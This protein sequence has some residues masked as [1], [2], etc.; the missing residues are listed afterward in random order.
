[1]AYCEISIPSNVMQIVA[2]LYM[3]KN[4]AMH[5]VMLNVP[6]PGASKLIWLIVS[7]VFNYWISHFRAPLILTKI[8]EGL[9]KTPKWKKIAFSFGQLEL[10]WN[11]CERSLMKSVWWKRNE[12]KKKKKLIFGVVFSFKTL[13]LISIKL[14]YLQQYIMFV[15]QVT[16]FSNF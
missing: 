9:I 1:M 6:L 3:F 5:V 8:R 11:D 13:L 4:L 12:K 7:R 2:I 16:L 15:I 10:I 14:T